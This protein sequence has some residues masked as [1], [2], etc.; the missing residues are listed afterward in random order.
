MR[1]FLVALAIVA[2]RNYRGMGD[3]WYERGCLA[4]W[5]LAKWFQIEDPYHWIAQDYVR[6]DCKFEALI[7]YGKLMRKHFPKAQSAFGLIDPNW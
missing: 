2:D 5:Y 3:K 7:F 1:E 6:S 4:R